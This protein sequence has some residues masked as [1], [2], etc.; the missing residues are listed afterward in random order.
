[1]QVS[2]VTAPLSAPGTKLAGVTL[3][4]T[5]KMLDYNC[6]N[7]LSLFPVV[8]GAYSINMVRVTKNECF[9]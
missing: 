2:V 9:S 7:K 3:F 6:A 5:A 1:M 4:F 8:Y